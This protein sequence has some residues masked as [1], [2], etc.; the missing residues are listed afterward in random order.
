[1]EN[2][3][4]VFPKNKEN[5]PFKLMLCYNWNLIKHEIITND[6]IF[7][8]LSNIKEFTILKGING[9]LKFLYSYR[10]IIEKILYDNEEV[11]EIES[12]DVIK[13]ISDYFYLSLILKN[14]K[15]IVNYAYS[16]NFI[17]EINEHRKTVKESFKKIIISKI[18]LELIEN[19]KNTDKYEESEYEELE[20][21]YKENIGT[22]ESNIKF[23]KELNGN[24]TLENIQNKKI[25]EIYEELIL[26]LIKTKKYGNANIINQLEL[27]NINI[28]E[29]VIDH[30]FDFLEKYIKNLNFEI[31]QIEQLFNNEILS[32]IYFLFKYLLKE[33]K[34]QIFI[35]KSPFLIQIKKFILNIIK[36]EKEKFLKCYQSS[37]EEI[38]NK[39]RFILKI[40][41]DSNYYLNKLNLNNI[42]NSN[43]NNHRE[44]N[45]N[46]YLINPINPIIGNN[47]SNNNSINSYYEREAS[48][49]DKNFSNQ[50]TKSRNNMSN[51]LSRSSVKNQKNGN[52]KEIE[53]NDFLGNI[54]NNEKLLHDILTNST[55]KFYIEENDENHNFIYDSITAEQKKFK[56]IEDIKEMT[57]EYGNNVKLY[58]SF[59]KFI[60]FL[61]KIENQIKKNYKKKSRLEITMKFRKPQ[62]SN[63][64][65]SYYDIDCIYNYK[66]NNNNNNLE[67]V[68]ENCLDNKNLEGISYFLNDINSNEN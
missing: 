17:K 10:N 37:D 60:S 65:L 9:Y 38:K 47:S 18:I 22:I 64:S 19:Y 29:T 66:L 48:S 46:N 6:P 55:F 23:F 8:L 21:I 61:N 33:L 25:D 34:E 13:A 51:P 50:P 54:I 52:L 68:D 58:K 11:L 1:M 42:Q 67:F 5:L 45:K 14:N 32:F 16:I 30:L 57:L 41:L 36:K 27:E 15:N 43:L 56:K 63:E 7:N 31:S 62:N 4:K 53:N 44:E 24:W 2:E 26:D 28:T 40:F 20:S 39:I 3:K 49:Y 35:Y 59:N 12:A